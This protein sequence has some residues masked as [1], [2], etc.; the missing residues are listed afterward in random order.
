MITLVAMDTQ[1]LQAFVAVADSGSFS[2]A[3]ERLHLSQPAISKRV[4]ALEE[5]TG[6]ALFDRIG[7]SVRLTEAGH[8]LLPHAHRVLREL[9]DSQHA[10]SRLSGAVSGRLSIG[11]SHHIGLHHLPPVLRQ[12]AQHFPDV[13][14]DIDFMDSEA[15]IQAVE[16]G[17]LELGIVTLPP[18]TPARLNSEIIWPDPMSIVAAPTHP[19]AQLPF[20]CVDDL[21]RHPALLPD[22]Q[23]FTHGIVRKMLAD[24]GVTPRVRL[25]TNYL[26]TLKMLVSVGLGWSALPLTMTDEHVIALDVPGIQLSRDL[27]VVWHARRSLSRAAEALLDT[28]RTQADAG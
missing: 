12:Y 8:T 9:E 13:D 24:H 10:L 6:K 5:R 20:V 16:Q 1:W 19:L 18:V 3:A 15:A 27:G 25:A 23:T 4:A 26:E 21:A 22:V 2:Q 14:L 17:R 28:L 7:R 11:T